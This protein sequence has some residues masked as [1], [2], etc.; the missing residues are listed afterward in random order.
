MTTVSKRVGRLGVLVGGGPAP[1]INSTIS[2]AV[3]EAV[4]SGLAVVGIYDGFEHLMEG[5]SDNVREL[6]IA[7]VSRIRSQGGSVLRTS[8]ANPTRTPQ[9]LDRTVEV[10]NVLGITHAVTIGGDDTAFSAF[11]VAKASGGRSESPMPP[12]R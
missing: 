8:R 5:R 2:A 9:D 10:L 3:I 11:E 6:T 12:R 1:G 7:D 4:N